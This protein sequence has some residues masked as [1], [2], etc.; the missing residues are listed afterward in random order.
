MGALGFYD[1]FIPLMGNLKDNDN[2]ATKFKI[3]YLKSLIIDGKVYKF[4]SFK[5]NAEI[6][7]RTLMDRKVWF[8]FYRTLNDETEFEIKYKVK[9]VMQKT[10]YQQDYIKLVVN[11]L[12]EMYDVF[13]LTYK[14]EKYMWQDYAD[15]GNGICLV[16][17]VEDYDFL[18][19]V[20]YC[21]KNNI[22]FSKMIIA[23]LKEEDVRALSIIPWVIKNQYN[24]TVRLDSTREKEVR[25]LYCPY[26]L[27]EFNG[28][29]VQMNIKER[30]GYK[31][32]AK[33]YQDFGLSLSNV[34][35]GNKIEKG[36]T[37]TLLGY[38]K[39]EKIEYSF[40]SI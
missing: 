9:K 36:L 32:F 40:I 25:I 22:D 14:Q 29:I 27:A 4:M 35:I 33:S 34:V 3:N 10:G 13:S 12:T 17:D 37:E 26:D 5:E 20:E 18:Y 30:K 39:M 38:L 15:C 31:G 24:A 2:T 6:K 19:P 23:A 28:G 8:S 1:E 21:E 11:C 16:F 7:L